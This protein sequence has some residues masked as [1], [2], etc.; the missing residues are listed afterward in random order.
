MVRQL[1]YDADFKFNFESGRLNRD[2]FTVAVTSLPSL[3]PLAIRACK[4]ALESLL[5]VNGG[6]SPYGVSSDDVRSA[7]NAVLSRIRQQNDST[8]FWASKLLESEVR[9]LPL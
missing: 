8:L 9:I 1:T 7:K 2:Y 4:D 3:L 5:T 6:G